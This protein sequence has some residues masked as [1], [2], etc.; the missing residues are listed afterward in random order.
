[1]ITY[2]CVKRRGIGVASDLKSPMTSD[3]GIACDLINM[4]IY[5]SID[6]PRWFL[7]LCLSPSREICVNAFL[8]SVFL[9][10][11]HIEHDNLQCW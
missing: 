11:V 10:E 5:I 8:I 4:R 1:M 9:L 2:I 3:L 6:P 7:G